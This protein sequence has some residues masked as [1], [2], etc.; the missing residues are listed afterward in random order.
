MFTFMKREEG[1]V[2]IQLT[3]KGR[4][5]RERLLR[6]AD[7]LFATRG[8]AET[9]MRDVA[10]EAGCAVGLAYRYF[11][12]REDLAV[13][14]YEDLAGAFDDACAVVPAGALGVRFEQVMRRRLELLVQH[15]SMLRALLPLALDA[16]S[17][18]GVWSSSTSQVRAR[19]LAV[20]SRVA[21][22]DGQTAELLYLL[23]LAVLLA[24]LIDN[25]KDGRGTEAALALVVDGLGFAGPLLGNPIAGL[26]IERLRAV[27]HLLTNNSDDNDDNDDNN[28]STGDDDDDIT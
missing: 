27:I 16:S 26:V 6:S 14:L 10:A 9:T 25:S 28:N 19:V 17:G 2:E 11:A 4:A 20:F 15:R 24:W 1:A 18:I 8:Y 13:A 5:T 22:G 3:A 7:H 21:D 23:H 12:R